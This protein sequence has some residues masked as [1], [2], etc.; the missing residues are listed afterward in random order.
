MLEIEILSY[1]IRLSYGY[2][3]PKYPN[4]S[5][6]KNLT[7]QAI[8]NFRFNLLPF[9]YYFLYASLPISDNPLNFSKTPYTYAGVQTLPLS[10][11]K[12]KQKLS[13]S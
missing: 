12:T 7:S 5:V 4:L 3:A 10:H 13:C 11:P 6:T 2:L 9:F 1:P 8:P